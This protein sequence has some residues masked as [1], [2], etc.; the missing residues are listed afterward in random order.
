MKLRYWSDKPNHE[1]SSKGQ[2]IE[3]LFWELAD[4]L[5]YVSAQPMWLFEL[6]KN[7]LET[8]EWCA[9]GSY[10]EEGELEKVSIG[11]ASEVN[12]II[13]INHH[14]CLEASADEFERLTEYYRDKNS[15]RIITRIPPGK[16]LSR[17][18]EVI[19]KG[20][21]I[22]LQR[23]GENLRLEIVSSAYDKKIESA[24]R[25]RRIAP[26]SNIPGVYHHPEYYSQTDDPEILWREW[27][28]IVLKGGEHLA[29]FRSNHQEDYPE[30]LDIH[31]RKHV[32][33]ISK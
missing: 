14:L 4:R 1:Q 2:D 16:L 28:I 12:P 27:V 29:E 26:H 6:I 20:A 32:W 30:K 23:V 25:F 31:M 24:S 18:D 19:N 17:P 15:D 9:H 5:E 22:E 21:I 33:E 8:H 7:T 3:P 11:V 13:S 10:V